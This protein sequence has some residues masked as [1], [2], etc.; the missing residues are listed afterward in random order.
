MKTWRPARTQCIMGLLLLQWSAR[1]GRDV[2]RRSSFLRL[3]DN[4]NDGIASRSQGLEIASD[5]LLSS[6]VLA[7]FLCV[8]VFW[9]AACYT[10]Y[11]WSLCLSEIAFFE[12]MYSWSLRNHPNPCH[13]TGEK[14]EV[15]S[16]TG[17]GHWT[18]GRS[19][20]SIL[21]FQS[22]AFT[23]GDHHNFTPFSK[24]KKNQEIT[25]LLVVNI[26]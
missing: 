5:S 22:T 12:W 26:N 8:T 20:V 6:S 7:V 13:F 9:E 3:Q 23:W 1:R 4:H 10:A 24:K 2:V 16:W 18:T 17:Q 25:N 11:L 19:K 21:V 15:W 14:A